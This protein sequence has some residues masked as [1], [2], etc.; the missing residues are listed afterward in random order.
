VHNYSSFLPLQSFFDGNVCDILQFAFVVDGEQ[1]D[2]I[3]GNANVCDDASA[4]RFS[5]GG[6]GQAYFVA[7]VTEF[8]AGSRFLFQLYN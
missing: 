8:G 4:T 5:F 2:G 7:V 6:D 3:T 1:V